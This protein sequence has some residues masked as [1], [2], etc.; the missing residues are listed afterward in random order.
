MEKMEQRNDDPNAWPTA[1]FGII[2]ACLVFVMTVGLQAL[3]YVEQRHEID[4]K[5]TNQA[6]EAVTRLAAEQQEKLHSYR[7]VDARAGIAAIP[8]DRAMEL[9]I[10]EIARGRPGGIE[11]APSPALATPPPPSSATSGAP[12]GAGAH[13]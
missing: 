7:W 3:F 12:H 1:V 4:R 11:T 5:V 2:G 13:R 6:P 9:T 10:R 8:I